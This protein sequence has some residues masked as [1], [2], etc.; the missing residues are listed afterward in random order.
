MS[1]SQP[2][3]PQLRRIVTTHDEQGRSTVWIDGL[4][5]NTRFSAGS[6]SST[7]IWATEGSPACFLGDEDAGDWSLGTAPP[8]GGSRVTY[9]TLEPASGRT[10]MHRTDT[11]DYV[12][13]VTGEV[14]V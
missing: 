5:T 2:E 11:V 1:E 3:G 13:C 10:R 14:V 7:L 4:P 6:A 9:L 12:V 8:P